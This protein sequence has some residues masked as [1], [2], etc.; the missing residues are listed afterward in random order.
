[1]VDDI[2]VIP[3]ETF[4]TYAYMATWGY[5]MKKTTYSNIVEYM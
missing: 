2:L 3:N 4:N 1:M 5:K